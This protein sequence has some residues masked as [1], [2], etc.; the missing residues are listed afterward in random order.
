M[1][2]ALNGNSITKRFKQAGAFFDAHSMMIYFI[3]FSCVLTGA[4]LSL[5][6]AL[7]NPTD[8][9]NRSQKISEIQST[10]FDTETIEKIKR[11]NAQQQTNLDAAP[12]GKRTNP[13]GE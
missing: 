9:D 11:L 6:I 13:F 7:N 3:V 2:L 12:V 4:I 1:K 5:N 8:E 10:K